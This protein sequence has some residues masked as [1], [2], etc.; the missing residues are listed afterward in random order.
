[1]EK[2]KDKLRLVI[3]FIIICILGA[4]V[5]LFLHRNEQTTDDAAIDGH[6][7]VISTK[8]PGYVKALNIGDNQWVKAGDVLLEID[9]DDYIIRRDRSKAALAAAKAQVISADATLKKNQS[10]LNRMK[11]LTTQAR[12]QEQLELALSQ[13]Q[14]SQAVVDQLQAHVEE[15]QA[16]LAQAE[17]DLAD[18]K[19]IAPMDGFITKRGVERGNYVQ[20]GQQLVSLVGTDI[21]V[22]A[23]FK[24]TQLKNIRK[25]DAVDIEVDAF[26]HVKITGKVDSIQRGTGAYFSAFPPENATGNYVKI[27]QRVP[28]KIVFDNAQDAN[29]HLGLGMSVT[30]VV[31]T[32][33]AEQARE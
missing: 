23:N 25:G 1:M 30:P 16:D 5:Y 15:A 24:E 7:V 12:S 13:V 19:I 26:P 2:H 9:P 29:I 6:N 11:R 18:T 21:W 4:S 27:I 32:G 3:A 14:T 31:H 33:S 10:D 20:P 8:V 22:V 28:V 17:K